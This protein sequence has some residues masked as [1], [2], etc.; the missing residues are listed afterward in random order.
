MFLDMADMVAC[1]HSKDPNTKVGAVIAK[2]SYPLSFG[3][4]GIIRGYPDA[5]HILE[6][7]DLKLIY[8]EHAERNAIYNAVR[9]NINIMGA[10]IYVTHFPCHECMRAIIQ[11]GL[12]RVVWYSNEEYLSGKWKKSVEHSMDMAKQCEVNVVVY[13]R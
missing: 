7:R 1:T 13:H 8:T 6:N 9:N 11:S 10:S 3:Y 12:S 5:T 2:E 4:N